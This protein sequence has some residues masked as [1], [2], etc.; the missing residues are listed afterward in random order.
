MMEVR[1]RWDVRD[2]GYASTQPTVWHWLQSIGSLNEGL[3]ANSALWSVCV[4]KA[5][6]VG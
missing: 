6:Q 5:G 4:S 1:P 2:G 3:P